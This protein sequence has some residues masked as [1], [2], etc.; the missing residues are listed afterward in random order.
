MTTLNRHAAPHRDDA[1]VGASDLDRVLCLRRPRSVDVEVIAA[2]AGDPGT[3]EHIP[4][5]ALTI[6]ASRG[7][8]RGWIE[9]W[10]SDA[11]GYWVVEEPHSGAVIGW[12]GVRFVAA[13]DLRLQPGLSR[14]PFSLGSGRRNLGR[15]PRTRDRECAFLRGA[16]DRPDRP[17][18]R[19][20]CSHGR[21]GGP[22]CRW[23]R[24]P[25]LA[26]LRRPGAPAR[27]PARV[28]ASLISQ[29]AP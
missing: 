21:E 7:L 18:Q 8:V 27:P 19:R 1:R 13:A 3:S 25:A 9:D 6:V 5:G 22:A 26:G 16:R 29:R 17:R 20:V 2:I 15:A 4:A 11:V 12:G 24:S 14:R 10:A 28:T 23:A